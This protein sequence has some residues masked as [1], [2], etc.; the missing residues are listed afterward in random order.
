M[1]GLNNVSNL[2]D[3][4]GDLERMVGY[5]Y[6]ILKESGELTMGIDDGSILVAGCQGSGSLGN[7][8]T[9]TQSDFE[10]Y[11]EEQKRTL[12]ILVQK[13]NGEGE[14]LDCLRLPLWRS[15]S[16]TACDTSHLTHMIVLLGSWG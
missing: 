3:R 15:Q 5:L 13:I 1:L 7:P 10:S 9:V 8:G 6:D 16:L 4:V 2:T 11:K 14:R 12:S